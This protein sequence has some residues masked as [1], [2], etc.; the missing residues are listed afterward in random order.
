MHL[1]KRLISLSLL[2]LILLTVTAIPALADSTTIYV[3]CANGGAGELVTVD[4]TADSAY[5]VV[6]DQKT[7]IEYGRTLFTRRMATGAGADT[8]NMYYGGG[9]FVSK[10][11]LTAG[12]WGPAGTV[13]FVQDTW[14]LESSEV[15]ATVSYTYMM[16]QNGI[17][18]VDASDWV[19]TPKEMLP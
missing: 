7:G 16:D 10:T 17:V 6:V 11:F 3:Y 4:F 12:P 5:K 18:R 2:V 9:S 1:N 14:K 13:A 8:Q 19:C 15:V